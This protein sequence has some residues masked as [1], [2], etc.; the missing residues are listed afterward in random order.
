MSYITQVKISGILYNVK[1]GGFWGC[2]LLNSSN[3]PDFPT[4]SPLFYTL[5]CVFSD[6]GFFLNTYHI[7]EI[8]ISTS[9]PNV[10]CPV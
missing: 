8:Q 7:N 3:F 1:L 10:F 9:I 5:K 4:F 6:F 2:N